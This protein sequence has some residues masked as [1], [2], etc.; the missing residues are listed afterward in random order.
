MGSGT[1]KNANLKI[2]RKFV[3]F[4]R[5]LHRKLRFVGS[6][7]AEVLRSNLLRETLTCEFRLVKKLSLENF[8]KNLSNLSGSKMRGFKSG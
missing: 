7:P 5:Y 4:I 8:K 1:L 3:N 6:K 2:I